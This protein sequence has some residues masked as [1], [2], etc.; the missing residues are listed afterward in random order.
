LKKISAKIKISKKKDRV[1]SLLNKFDNISIFPSDKNFQIE[2]FLEDSKIK[3]S[4]LDKIKKE[5]DDFE[6]S[7][8]KRR[9]WVIQNRKDDK[10]VRSELFFI[11]QGLS[12]KK[13]ENKK[14]KLVIPGNN[15]LEQVPMHL[16]IYQSDV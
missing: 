5:F 1:L 9:D 11:S 4:L 15:A 14:Y 13:S 2:L 10:G 8:I 6:C 16:L 7:E 12:N 3:N